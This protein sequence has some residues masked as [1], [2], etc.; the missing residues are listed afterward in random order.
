M[1]RIVTVR[2]AKNKKTMDT[3]MKPEK[4]LAERP[5]RITMDHSTSDSSVTPN[6]KANNQSKCYKYF[7][8]KFSAKFTLTDVLL[9]VCLT[10]MSQAEGPQPQIW[11]RVGDAAQTVLYGVDRLMNCHVRKVKLKVNIPACQHETFKDVLTTSLGGLERM[12]PVH[13]TDSSSYWQGSHKLPRINGL[14]SPNKERHLRLKTL[15]NPED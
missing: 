8:S 4:S 1:R 15:W 11:C 7:K 9:L 3:A 2:I 5:T 12:P 6:I 14:E 13:C 10:C